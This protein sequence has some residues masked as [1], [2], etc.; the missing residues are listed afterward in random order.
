M[1]SKMAM[2]SVRAQL[3]TEQFEMAESSAESGWAVLMASVK[4]GPWMESAEVMDSFALTMLDAWLLAS[5]M[6][7]FAELTMA[8]GR[9][10][11]SLTT[12]PRAQLLIEPELN[13][14]W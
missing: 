3:A 1:A 11:G 4:A 5:G 13:G 7:A 12:R 9:R 8:A 14:Y 6:A 2:A 10:R